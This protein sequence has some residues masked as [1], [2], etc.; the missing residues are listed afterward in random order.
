MFAAI[1]YFK[2]TSNFELT[3]KLKDEFTEE[4]AR[5]YFDL[6]AYKIKS[7]ELTQINFKES[8]NFFLP[9]LEK[10]FEPSQ[11]NKINSGFNYRLKL[12]ALQDTHPKESLQAEVNALDLVALRIK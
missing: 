3:I 4:N 8:N 10:G 5:D 7:E 12:P 9:D 1:N 2:L 6:L 11:T